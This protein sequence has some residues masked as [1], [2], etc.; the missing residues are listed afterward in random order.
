MTEAD[1]Q[2]AVTPR[3]ESLRGEPENTVDAKLF[4]DGSLS[5]EQTDGEHYDIVELTAKEVRKLR[6]FLNEHLADDDPACS[7]CGGAGCGDCDV[8]I[9][10][11]ILAAILPEMIADHNEDIS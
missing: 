7:T 5:L 1:M 4:P 6:D 9:D 11:D 3:K 10:A 2:A 8:D